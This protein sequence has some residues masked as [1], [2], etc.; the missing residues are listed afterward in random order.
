[1]WFILQLINPDFSNEQNTDSE[2]PFILRP[3]MTHKLD[4]KWNAILGHSYIPN[5]SLNNIIMFYTNLKKFCQFSRVN[6]HFN[7]STEGDR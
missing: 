4:K 3:G 5:Y 2:N 6:K 7:S 1:M